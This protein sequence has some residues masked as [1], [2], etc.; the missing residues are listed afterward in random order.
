M[1]EAGNLKRMTTNVVCG[2]GMP[3]FT[4]LCVQQSTF[5][6]FNNIVFERN[7]INFYRK[8]KFSKYHTNLT[9]VSYFMK[10]HVGSVPR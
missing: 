6:T 10:H 3:S 4:E 5:R 7:L 8:M 9:F 1:S 2:L